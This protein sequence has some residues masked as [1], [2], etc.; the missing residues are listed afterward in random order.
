MTEPSLRILFLTPYFRPYV[1]GIE[2][3]IEQFSA[4]L[5]GD[6][7]VTAVGVLT[8]KY[9]FPRIPQP[10][11]AD[12]ETTVEGISIFRLKGHP[13]RSLPVYSVPL[14]WFSPIQ[15]RRYIEEFDPN[16]IHFVG[17]GWF[18]GH[19][20][21]WV[22]YRRRARFVFTPSFHTLPLRRQWIRPINA[23]L[24]KVMD[25]VITLTRQEKDQVS[26]AYWVHQSKLEVVGWGVPEVGRPDS[27]EDNGPLSI[28][29]VGRL[30][31]HKGQEWLL[32]VYFRARTRFRQST[33]LLLVG[34]DE[35]M[36][37]VIR[38]MVETAGL[39]HEVIITGEISDEELLEWYTRSN[40][41][42]LFSQYEAFG[43]VF[44]EAMAHG[45]PV[46]THDVGA[47]RELLTKG[48]VIVA[49]FDETSAEDELVRLVNDN[50][51][52]RRLGQDARNYALKWFTWASVAKRYLRIYQTLS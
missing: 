8:T 31:H 23:F 30:G 4:Q 34:R 45:I 26:R 10:S 50:N 35:G 37:K 46:L 44:F 3:A 11:W 32:K 14:V 16:V 38:N 5:M 39:S 36:E 41:L 15:I 17:D 29:C 19:F 22:W 2:R 28:L 51:L 42:V 47:N 43:L 33:R 13:Q 52:R 21:A 20:W 12:R 40:L 6:P 24:C 27:R 9:A 49:P 25:S 7:T 48:A 18:W 1:G